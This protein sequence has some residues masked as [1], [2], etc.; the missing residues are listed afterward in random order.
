MGQAKIKRELA[1]MQAAQMEK[2]KKEIEKSADLSV[3]VLAIRQEYGIQTMRSHPEE[4][5]AM[6]ALFAAQ[7]EIYRGLETMEKRIRSI[8]NGYRDYKLV[9][10]RVDALVGL[11]LASFQDAKLFS[12]VDMIRHTGYKVFFNAYA[13]A[14]EDSSLSVVKME[15]LDV[16]ISAAHEYCKMCDKNCDKC[17]LGK[18]LDGMI[19]NER[20][21]GESWSMIDIG[22]FDAES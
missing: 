1:K 3:K 2:V 9:M 15:N 7:N 16:L 18:A 14:K 20:Q 17:K 13:A 6:V 21:K 5:D 8:K 22:N 19:G 4:I 10:N 11:L 12:L